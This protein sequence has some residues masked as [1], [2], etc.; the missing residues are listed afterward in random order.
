MIL[1]TIWMVV[2]LLNLVNAL[3]IGNLYAA[4]G[5]LVAAL[6]LTLAIINE[7]RRHHEHITS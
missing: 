5:W 1:N 3:V 4:A 6:A 7:N 2:I